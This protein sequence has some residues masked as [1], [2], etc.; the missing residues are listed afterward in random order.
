MSAL[1]EYWDIFPD[2][3]S[4]LPQL[5]PVPA[6]E[7]PGHALPRQPLIR[8]GRLTLRRPEGRDAEAITA[9]L[10][11]YRV[12]KMLTRVPQPYHLEDAEEWLVSLGGLAQEVWVFAITLGGVRAILSPELEAANGNV[13]DR[14]IGV[15]SIE[16]REA[17]LRTGWHLGYWLDEAHWG[18]GIMTDAVNAVVAR[19][20]SVMMGETLFSSVMA[21][22]PGSLRIQ[23]KLGFDVT[24]VE[25]VYAPSRAEGVRLITTELTFGGYMPM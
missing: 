20:F 25:D 14:L 22:N 19:F 10:A 5:P 6:I 13:S 1:I 16:W 3:P 2:A 24:G 11:N 9:A 21:D 12:A 7:L 17:G 8:T 15:V 18:K 4:L 23:G